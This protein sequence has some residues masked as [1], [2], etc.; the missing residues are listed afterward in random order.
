MPNVSSI[1]RKP[2]T[3]I[4]LLVV[5]A[6]IAIL[7][8]MLLPVLS[9]ARDKARCITCANK[10]SQLGVTASMY[11]DDY[12]DYYF[13]ATIK[14]GT[15]T[16][17]WCSNNSTHPFPG[18]LNRKFTEVPNGPLDCPTNPWGRAGWK[19]SDYGFNVMLNDHAT[20]KAYCT[21]NRG[22]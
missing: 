19:Y 17:Y 7:A 3:L 13:P 6:I 9:K 21:R 11:A 16:R 5:I 15:S 8:S 18:Y 10:I 4:E 12:D 22:A 2:F 1:H 20:R 14:D